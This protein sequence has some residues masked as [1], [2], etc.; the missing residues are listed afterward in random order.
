ML[1]DQECSSIIKKHFPE[2]DIVNFKILG[3]GMYS[4]ACL[5]ND[6]IVF[7]VPIKNEDKCN[8]VKKEVFLLKQLENKLSFEI[9]RILYDKEIDSGRII[10]ETLVHGVTYTQ[11]LHDSFDEETKT[12]IL[13]QLG[14]IARELHSVKIDNQEGIVSVSDYKD[15]ISVFH[16]YFSDNVK[17]CFSDSDLDRIN[18]VCDRYEY[19]STHYPVDPVLVH[20]DLHFCNM[21]FDTE[22][23]KIVGLL[24][25]AAA[26]LSEPARDMHYYYGEGAKAFL[27]GYGDNGDPYLPE[28]QKFQ[29]IINFLSNIGEDIQ[30]NKSP[31]KNIK[32]L[33]SI[34]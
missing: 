30:N 10:G 19:L 1:T 26:H 20:A 3:N 31:D 12:D 21:T 4:V 17:K 33:L 24:D 23:K 29:C 8:D 2:L 14:R 5:V 9:P 28:R 15:T 6:N 16:E 7:K 13:H 25:W 27:D 22:N 11:E 34:L 32:K 18:K